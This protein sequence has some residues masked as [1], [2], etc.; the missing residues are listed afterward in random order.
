MGASESKPL[1]HLDFDVLDLYEVLEVELEATPE[2]IKRAY[3]K[4]ALEHHPDKNQ[5]DVVGSTRRFARIQEAYETL[6][7]G[8]KR[9][10][11]NYKRATAPPA[12]QDDKAME[13]EFT[14]PGTHRDTSISQSSWF[15]YIFGFW[16]SSSTPAPKEH[17]I[18]EPREYYAHTQK[19]GR[20]TGISIFDV[21]TYLESHSQFSW[22]EV[23]YP[24]PHS[25]YAYFDRL[26]AVLAID[27]RLWGNH[28]HIPS[29]G[30]CQMAWCQSDLPSGSSESTAKDFYHFWTKFQT[31]KQFEWIKY[32]QAPYPNPHV[33]NMIEKENRK[34]QRE[35]QKQYNTAIQELVKQ[36]MAFDPRYF[37]HLKMRET[38]RQT[39]PPT[40]QTNNK[41][42][43]KNKRKK[44]KN[45]TVF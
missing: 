35:I 38:R 13:E 3:R 40:P 22:E 29:F 1:T 28:E 37:W 45:S 2:D 39:A 32:Y 21:M 43:K 18:M 25:A 24:S 44:N 20:G 14:M 42:N 4:K 36:L 27:E 9:E 12:S 33:E 19:F 7:D 6:S 16:S 17:K 5:G 11:Y 26:F 8:H 10:I 41:K 30:N 15:Q 34:V 23:D 31:K